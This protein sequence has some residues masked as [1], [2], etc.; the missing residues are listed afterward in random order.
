MRRREFITLLGGSAAAWPTVVRGQQP[1]ERIRRVGI[2]VG[3]AIANSL[4]S[5]ASMAAFVQGLAAL[6]WVEGR[7]LRL[8]TFWAVGNPDKVKEYEAELGTLASAVVAL[9]PEVIMTNGT[10]NLDA[11][12]R[13]TRTI[14]IVFV[15]VTDQDSAA[16]ID[17][18]ARTGI[19][20]TGFTNFQYS[21]AAKWL[22]LLNEIA[23]NVRRVGILRDPGITAG[24][25]QWSVIQ[26]AAS[27]LGMEVIEANLGH[28][29]EIVRAFGAFART[30]NSGLIVTTS[31]LAT[32]HR[33]LIISL[34][35]QHKL[36]AV[37]S[38][39]LFV[40]DGGLISYGANL[41]DQYR[42][43]AGYVDRILKGQN[44]ADLPVQAPAKY[45]LVINLKT[46]KALGLTVPPVLLDRADEVIK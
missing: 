41:I 30:A 26:A 4:E 44:L 2:L 1:P 18:Q 16:F 43:A 20:A 27:S 25:E 21:L 40:A 11:M 28:E 35:A 22:D 12:L 7:N 17:G 31:T 3:S 24:V 8:D 29:A 36:P 13:A 10:R 34:A 39:R 46:A 38:R 33:E 37:Y 42:L 45:E 23:P 14:P 15:N 5:R 9:A 32:I 6:G 19:N